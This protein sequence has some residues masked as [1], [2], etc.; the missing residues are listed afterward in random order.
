MC[1]VRGGILFLRDRQLRSVRHE[2]T[3]TTG[4]GELLPI[5]T[6]EEML[7]I[8]KDH[9]KLFIELKGATA[10]RQ[11]ADDIVRIV[12]EKDCTDDVVLISLAYDVIDYAETAYPEFETGTLFFAGIGNVAKLNCD[13]LIMEEEMASEA[14]IRQ[15]HN[16]GKQA[17]VWTVN[18][19]ES[20]NNFL[21][22]EVD[23]IITDEIELAERVQE[24]L[25]ARTEFE[26]LEAQLGEFWK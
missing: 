24:E 21:D 4:N 18:T 26:E 10:D 22:S 3:D 7:D 9:E 15:I 1:R 25:Y 12:R 17:V 2:I 14:R 20:M 8:I 5:V 11:M 23:G 6:I 19:E 13:L 16:A